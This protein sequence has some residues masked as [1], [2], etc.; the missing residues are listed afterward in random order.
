MDINL[1]A[2][3]GN[4]ILTNDI[5]LLFQ[6]V[7]LAIKIISGEIWNRPMGLDIQQYVF[8]KYVSVYR[9]KQEMKNFIVNECSK[10]N[11][12]NWDLN[13]NIMNIEGKDLIKIEF[14]INDDVNKEAI[15][16]QFLIQ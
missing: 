16:Q 8:N 6:E 10:A 12:F 14:T 7:E 3:D 5:D 11:L 4:Y 15:K 2:T 1:H 9:M 13:V